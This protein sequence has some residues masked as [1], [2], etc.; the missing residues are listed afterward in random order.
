LAIYIQQHFYS[1]DKKKR[2][3]QAGSSASTSA[4][5]TA[6]ITTSVAADSTKR[7]KQ[8]G[9]GVNNGGYDDE[10]DD[11]IFREGELWDDRFYIL[12]QLGRGSFGQVFEAYDRAHNEHVAIKII[13]NRKTFYNQALT[14]IR[15]LDFL[16]SKDPDDTKYMGKD[17]KGFVEAVH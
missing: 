12:K 17:S 15:I 8:G 10:N 16:N 14:E 1:Q 6:A 7:T 13:K 9:G 3:T 5:N 2:V 4:T 11:Y